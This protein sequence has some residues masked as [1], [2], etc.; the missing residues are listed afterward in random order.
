MIYPRAEDAKNYYIMGMDYDLGKAAGV[1]VEQT[2]FWLHDKKGMSLEDAY[3]LCSVGV[4]F[5]ISEAVDKNLVMYGTIPKSFFK[6][7]EPYWTK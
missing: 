2:I 7:Q 5:A 4:D 6:K 1:A 3:H